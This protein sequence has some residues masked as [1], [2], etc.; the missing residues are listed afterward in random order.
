LRAWTTFYSLSIKI[1][2]IKG[3]PTKTERGK[4][5]TTFYSLSFPPPSPTMTVNLLG[6]EQ[7]L[8]FILYP[9][10]PFPYNDCKVIG[11]GNHGQPTPPHT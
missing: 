11:E 3:M 5:W 9:S 8:S 10:L 6:G 2:G 7:E 1:Y 4:P